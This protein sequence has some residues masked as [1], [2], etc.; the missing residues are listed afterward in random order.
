MPRQTRQQRR[1]LHA[2]FMQHAL[3]HN[4]EIPCAVHLFML[5]HS[6]IEHHPKRSQHKFSAQ[7]RGCRRAV[8]VWKGKAGVAQVVL[9]SGVD[10]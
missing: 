7:D 2:A 9:K 6:V 1:D 4:I 3:E 10:V 8:V 5:A